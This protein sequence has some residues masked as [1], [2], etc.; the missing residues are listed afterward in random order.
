M[1]IIT[2]A[3]ILSLAE[4]KIR[5]VITKLPPSIVTNIYSPARKAFVKLLTRESRKN[6]YIPPDTESRTLW[7]IKFQSGIFNAA[8]MFKHGEGYHTVAMQGA[9]AY[10]AGT[11]TGAFR[12]GN[13]GKGI[14]HPFMPYPLSGSASNWM[15]LPNEGHDYLAKKLSAIEK[16]DGCPVGISIAA[17]PELSDMAAMKE[18]VGGLFLFKN[19]GADFIELNE[20]CPNV[21][22][23]KK[24][25]KNE[26]DENLLNRLEFISKNFIQKSN[27]RPPVIVKLSNDTDIN[28]LPG[29]LDVLTGL[30]FGGVN[31]GN[32]S[33]E[34]NTYK[35]SISE[36][37]LRLYDYF[38]SNFGGGI[39]G[40][41]LKKR[42]LELSSYGSEYIAKHTPANEFYVIRTGG[43]ESINDI[44]ESEDSGIAL[45]QWFTGY[46]ENFARH[47]HSIYKHL[48]SKHN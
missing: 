16:M 26:L 3:E 25:G 36:S 33:T 2:A 30:G 40:R 4:F 32:T 8:G 48:Y 15:G 14:M 7:C 12:R 9:G 39:S 41:L 44:R 17:S 34:Y 45:C 20:S 11:S 22:H 35:Y 5:P 6:R 47:G 13:E 18:V 42:S 23:E 29:L 28:L 37:E 27:G 31:F 1:R 46:F 24:S 19:A 10:L 43:I 21:P 38:T